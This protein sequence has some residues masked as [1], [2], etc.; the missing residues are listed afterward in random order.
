MGARTPPRI[1]PGSELLA[2]IK[3]MA[4]Q[5]CGRPV[6]RA[7]DGIVIPGLRGTAEWHRHSRDPL[8]YHLRPE[9]AGYL[10]TGHPFAAESAMGKPHAIAQLR[11]LMVAVW[12]DLGAETADVIYNH[13]GD[14]KDDRRAAQDVYRDARK[15]RS[16]WVKLGAWPWWPISAAYADGEDGPLGLGRGLPAKW[17]ELPRVIAT[18]EAWRTGSQR[19]L[20]VNRPEGP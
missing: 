9:V 6:Y 7:L 4:R 14:T 11:Q 12:K 15:G 20:R 5:G 1:A 19:P 2:L 3:H 16:L 8:N 13:L 10:D 18:F 17:W